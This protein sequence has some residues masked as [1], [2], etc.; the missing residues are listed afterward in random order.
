[1]LGTKIITDKEEIFRKTVK[2]TDTRYR[3]LLLLQLIE[4]V[5]TEKGSCIFQQ[6]GP[7][8]WNPETP[9]PIY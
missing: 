4:R 7:P 5:L 9:Q 1:M 3:E 2:T 6:K 8:D